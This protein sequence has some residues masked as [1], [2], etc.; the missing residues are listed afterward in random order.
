MTL[1]KRSRES[2]LNCTISLSSWLDYVVN[3]KIFSYHFNEHDKPLNLD[4]PE[5]E[6]EIKDVKGRPGWEF[7]KVKIES[8]TGGPILFE[9][10]MYEGKLKGLVD[11]EL[12]NHPAWRSR[13]FSVTRFDYNVA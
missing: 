11:P 1:E 6:L 13:W 7:K 5:I 8:L 12:A 2:S 9:G 4:K 10:T 3:D